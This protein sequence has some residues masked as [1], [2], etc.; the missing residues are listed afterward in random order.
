MTLRVNARR[1]SAQAY[2]E[3]PGGARRRGAG[4]RPAGG[5][6]RE[7]AAGAAACPGFAEGEVS[8]QDAAAQLAAPLLL[9]APAQQPGCGNAARRR[10]RARCLR[11]ARRQDRAP[12][13]AG[14]PRRAGARQRSEAPAARAGHAQ[15][16]RPEGDVARRRRARAGRLVGRPAVRRD[17]A[18]RA[19]QRLGHRAAPSRRALA[20]PRRATWRRCVQVQ[21]QLLDALWP[22]LA[23]GGRLA[24]LHLLGL[25][26]RRAGADRR[27]FATPGPTRASPRRP[28]RPGTCCR[29]PTI[30]ARARHP[31]PV[32]RWTD[33]S[34]PCSKN[35]ELAHLLTRI[36]TACNNRPGAGGAA[37][38][39][40]RCAALVLV[41]A[42]A[43]VAV[44]RRARA[45]RVELASLEVHAQ[46][47]QRAAELHHAL[48]AAAR[49][50]GRAAKGRAAA[51][52]RRGR[53]LPQPL[54][55]A[56]RARGARLAHLAPGL[57][58]ADA[59]L[60]RRASAG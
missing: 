25:Q 53:R 11:G 2:V 24:V 4:R 29:W 30:L 48:R 50:R 44:A 47:G 57:A 35:T 34:T 28:R 40:C 51:L 21:A 31:K 55:L 17:L 27:F 18:R 38:P 52:R 20:A 41:L 59:Q 3:A 36:E 23:P 60:P 46:R 9:G 42:C 13:R 33:S 14:R 58:A 19:V 16:P 39:A 10:A 15:S 7:A 43:A 8:V 54:V 12:A 22:L 6:A 56:R 45:S 37:W 26:G 32:H 1:G 5:R 49:R